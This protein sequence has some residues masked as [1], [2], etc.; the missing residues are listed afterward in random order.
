VQQ[1]P[2][3]IRIRQGILKS[4]RMCLDAPTSDKATWD[5]LR[6]FQTFS[7]SPAEGKA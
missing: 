7:G 6:T 3:N 4:D 2:V 5:K 1:C